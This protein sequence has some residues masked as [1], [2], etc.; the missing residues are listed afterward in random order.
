MGPS[1]RGEDLCIVQP[2][3]L[4]VGDST[5]AVWIVRKELSTD[6]HAVTRC[7]PS[8]ETDALEK[9]DV[10]P[11][12]VACV[13]WRTNALVVALSSGSICAWDVPVGKHLT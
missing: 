7:A 12:Q 13:S 6:T 1:S 9:V 8:W 4:A 11:G 3:I 2:A 10:Q 5:G